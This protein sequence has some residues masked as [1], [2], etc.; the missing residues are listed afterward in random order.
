MK[1]MMTMIAALFLALSAIAQPQQQSPE[2]IAREETDRLDQLLTLTDRQYKKIYKFNK[3]Q[4]QKLQREMADMRSGGRPEGRPEGMR[5]GMGDGGSRPQGMGPGNGKGRPEGMGQQKD[6]ALRGK[7][8]G[9]GPMRQLMEEQREERARKYRKVLT[10]EQYM[11]W[12]SFEA[13]REF[14]QVK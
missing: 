4:S 1:H 9:A 10:A 12:E 6:G 2:Q 13:E 8:P 5:P 7:G 11:R 14:R 3:R